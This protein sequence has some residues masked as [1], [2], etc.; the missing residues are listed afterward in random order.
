[1]YRKMDKILFPNKFIGGPFVEEIETTREGTEKNVPFFGTFIGGISGS[2]LKIIA[3][4]TMLIDHIGAAV[5]EPY[6]RKIMEV[7]G[8]T[9]R[10]DLFQSLYRIDMVLRSIGRL[11]FPIFCFLLVEGFMYTKNRR[12]YVVRLGI[13]ALISEIP[14][15]I[16]FNQSILEFSSQNVFFTLL[17]GLCTIIA[18]DVILHWEKLQINESVRVILAGIAIAAGMYLAYFCSTDYSFKGI[19]AIVVMYFFRQRKTAEMFVGCL[20]LTYFSLI[21]VYSF[22]DVIFVSLYNGK[23]GLKLKYIFYAFYPL[24][25]LFLHGIACLMGIF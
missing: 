3:L 11:A 10:E 12:K 25:L 8:I 15:D 20:A 4:V 2:T 19:I 23:R 9:G 7:Y 24:H 17:F 18:V 21:E 5:V 6:M 16:A 22:I 14:F 1:M 13:F